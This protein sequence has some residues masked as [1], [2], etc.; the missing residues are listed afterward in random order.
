MVE[1]RGSVARLG[2]EETGWENKE[3]KVSS[4]PRKEAHDRLV[5]GS[6]GLRN[7]RVQTLVRGKLAANGQVRK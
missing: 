6:L 7:R 3:A 5:E 2:R 4:N 1:N